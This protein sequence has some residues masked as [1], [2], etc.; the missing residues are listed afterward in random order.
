MS[1]RCQVTGSA[2]VSVTRC[3]IR[4]TA[5]HAVG[6]PISRSR[7]TTCPLKSGASSCGS[8]PRASRPST[9]TASRRWWRG[10]ADRDSGSDG[11]QRNPAARQASVHGGHR[12]HLVEDIHLRAGKGPVPPGH[13]TDRS[14]SNDKSP[15]PSKT[16]A[17][18]RCCPI[19]AK[20]RTAKTHL[21]VRAAWTSPRDHRER[22]DSEFL[23]C[24]RECSAVGETPG[25]RQRAGMN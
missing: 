12:L 14:N 23:W 19:P 13:R 10:C 5:P 25:S 24:D 7:S 8:A 18:W 6:H 22:V 17:K 4:T 15:A 20:P 21:Q 2:P 1:A 16:P 9:A 3:R 11:T